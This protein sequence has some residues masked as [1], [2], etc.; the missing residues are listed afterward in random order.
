MDN[1][2]VVIVI[3][4]FLVQIAIVGGII[5][6]VY[7]FFRRGRNSDSER[8]EG[9]GSLKQ[10]YFYGISFAALMAL[11]AGISLTV[12][13]LLNVLFDNQTLSTS[14]SNLAWG[15]S[16]FIVGLP[17]WAFHWRT[18]L[19]N[20]ADMPVERRSIIRKLYMY[21]TLAVSL[22]FLMGTSFEIMK[23][24]MLAG[25]FP[26]FSLASILPWAMVWGY[27][28]QIETEEGQRSVETRGIRRLYLYGAALVG[29]GMF[30]V[31]MGAI[32]H[33]L[34][35]DGYSAL[36]LVQVTLSE[37]TGLARES[38][39]SD[40]AVAVAGGAVYWTHW[41]RFAG[42]ERDSFFRW[43]FVFL[44]SVGGAATALASGGVIVYTTLSW[45]L[46]AA[47]ERAALH[48]EDM[49]GAL[50]I[51]SVGVIVWALFRRRMLDEA[52]GEYTEPIRR[53]YDHLMAALGLAA[54]A[55]A[56]FVV[57]NTALVVFADSL[58]TTLRDSD[59]WRSPVRH[60]I[61]SRCFQSVDDHRRS[62][63]WIPL[64]TSWYGRR[65]TGG[66]GSGGDCSL[67]QGLR[68]R[69]HGRGCACSPWRRRRHSV[70][71]PAGS[72]GR[73]DVGGHHSRP[74]PGS[75]N[76]T[77]GRAVSAVPLGHLP[78]GPGFPAGQTAR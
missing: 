21:L 71:D 6:V 19:R 17:I 23:W 16:L 29:G 56:S 30:A 8:D 72:A 44:T 68:L 12:Q 60:S 4:S 11:I 53:I 65:R 41:Y 62:G 20:V 34:L 3:V 47:T 59:A 38:L 69:C 14:S 9:R 55:G 49:P 40:L 48:F 73:G 15:L 31:G 26:E 52:I 61:L 32:V 1:F 36:F 13:S 51:A 24:A 67:T 33:T 43:V 70:R 74:D 10:V 5:Y 25:E 57:F 58:S 77:D 42:S 54:L 37:Q 18:I 28:W 78:G 64:A 66:P 75:G 63:R 35:K 39:R 50:V 27:H 76:R 2:T 46:G 45:L 22:G 7:A